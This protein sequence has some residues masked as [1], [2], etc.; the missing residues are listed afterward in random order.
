VLSFISEPLQGGNIR[1]RPAA[2]RK[3]NRTMRPGTKGSRGR[4]GFTLIELLVVIAIIAILAAIL[5]PVF[6]SARES[7]RKTSC[8]SNTRQMGNALSMYLQDY[9]ETFHKGAGMNSAAINGFGADT[10]IDGWTNWPWFY[11]P[12]VKNVDVF[13]CPSSP[14]GTEQLTA[15]NWGNDGNY[16]YNYSGLTRDQGTAPRVLAEID[17]P[18]DTFVFFDSGDPNVRAGDNDWP[19]LLEELDLNLNC[20]EN[21]ISNYSKESALRHQGRCNMTFADGH[22]KNI[23][24]NQLLTRNA[25]NV[26][27][28]MINWGDCGPNCPPPDVGPGKCFDPARI[29]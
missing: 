5:F 18:A 8:L 29:P 21:Q 2:A 17:R 13:N 3:E 14:D 1:S 19:G 23:T 27:P 26:P 12:Y 11:G 20:A 10:S 22:A 25:D 16:G 4:H 15:A 6:A 9:D 24:W 7:A 28:W